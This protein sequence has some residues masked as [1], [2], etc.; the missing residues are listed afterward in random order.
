MRLSK[1]HHDTEHRTP[2]SS[3]KKK[4][5]TEY[6]L[7]KPIKSDVKKADWEI[8]QKALKKRKRDQ[9]H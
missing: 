8:E 9:L 5:K 7:D 4:G 6:K 3:K 2:H 1:K